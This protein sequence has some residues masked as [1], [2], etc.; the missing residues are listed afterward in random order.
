MKQIKLW[1]RTQGTGHDILEIAW[2]VYCTLQM[3]QVMQ[4]IFEFVLSQL[5]YVD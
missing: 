4:D 2:N 3:C 5:I 1:D